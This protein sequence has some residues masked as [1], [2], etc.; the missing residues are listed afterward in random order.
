MTQRLTGMA[1]NKVSLVDRGANGRSFAVLKRATAQEASMETSAREAA[2][3]SGIAKGMAAQHKPG[4]LAWITKAIFPRGTS[5]VAKSAADRV[6]TAGWALSYVFDLIE[7]ES[8][9]DAS[10]DAGDAGSDLTSLR[11]AAQALTTYMAA[12]ATEV[13]SADDLADIAEEA[14]AYAAYCA[15]SYY[16]DDCYWKRDPS[17]VTKKG[18]ADA[19]VRKEIEEMD[20]AKLAELITKAVDAAVEKRMPT[21]AAPAA[22]PVAAAVE[23][24]DDAITLESLGE[25]IGKIADRLTPIEDVIAN[26]V[27]KAKGQRTSLD[28]A[29]DAPVKK[30]AM[31]A[32]MF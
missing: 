25:A 28:E 14:A 24:T 10:S 11:S 21:P 26:R 30:R 16:A 27:L 6:S 22:A 18:A 29:P 20:E 31:F 19:D 3:V 2:L 7:G 13:G 9:D 32:G 4:L 8:A 12:A 5:K 23:K 15:T 1:I 17:A